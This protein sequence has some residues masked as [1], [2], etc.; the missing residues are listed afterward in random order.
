MD[1]KEVQKSKLEA[2]TKRKAPCSAKTKQPAKKSKGNCSGEKNKP[3]FQAFVD[4]HRDET[5]RL[6]KLSAMKCESCV[7][8]NVMT[9]TRNASL[10]AMTTVNQLIHGAGGKKLTASDLTNLMAKAE[11][12]AIVLYTQEIRQ[13]TM[14]QSL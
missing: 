1:R 10:A 2:N 14:A 4:N 9:D 7:P 5:L 8:T 11:Q 6:L 3:D 13:K 12:D